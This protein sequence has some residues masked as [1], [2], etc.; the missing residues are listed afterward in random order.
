[1]DSFRILKG[2]VSAAEWDPCG[3]RKGPFQRLDGIHTS[4]ERDRVSGGMES[5]RPLK[6]TV[7]VLERDRFHGEKEPIP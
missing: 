7:S 4:G 2:T 1:M 5:L 3:W 6:G